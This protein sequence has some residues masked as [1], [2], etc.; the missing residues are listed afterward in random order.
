[1][2][3]RKSQDQ[4]QVHFLTAV[5]EPGP[6]SRRC[7]SH[8]T[9]KTR[10]RLSQ[11]QTRLFFTGIWLAEFRRRV[12]SGRARLFFGGA[13]L[14]RVPG[15][16]LFLWRLALRVPRPALLVWRLA[17]GV[18]RVGL[19]GAALGSFG[20]VRPDKALHRNDL[21]PASLVTSLPVRAS[22]SHP[23]ASLHENLV[24]KQMRRLPRALMPGREHAVVLKIGVRFTFF[25]LPS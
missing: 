15:L 23:R 17:L 19:P 2:A 11:Y 6:G 18:P 13:W 24:G 8:R 16:A 1:M 14:P 22:E 20:P 10:P 21:A 12:F 4:G 3:K 9:K 25:H 7:S 5:S